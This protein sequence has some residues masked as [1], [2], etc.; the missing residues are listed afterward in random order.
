[1]KIFA[2]LNNRIIVAAWMDSIGQQDDPAMANEVNI[3]RGACETSV[4]NT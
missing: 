1:M 4:I 2:Y 3:D